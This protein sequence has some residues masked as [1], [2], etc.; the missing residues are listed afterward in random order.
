[1]RESYSRNNGDHRYSSLTRG[2]DIRQFGQPTG[3]DL[4]ALPAEHLFPV[5]IMDLK[6]HASPSPT[7]C[8]ASSRRMAARHFEALPMLGIAFFFV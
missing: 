4:H 2:K 1:M 5:M 7:P 3:G 6:Q 8:T